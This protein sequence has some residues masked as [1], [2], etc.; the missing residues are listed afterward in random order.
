[1]NFVDEVKITVTAGNGGRGSISFRREK[2][3]P[4]GGPDGGDGG[5]GGSVYLVT[6][7][8]INTLSK[9]RFQRSFKAANGQAG[10]ARQCS[11]RRA[12]D[13][14]IPVPIGT[15]VYDTQTEELIGDL[16]EIGQQVLVAQGGTR[17]LGNVHFKSSTNRTPRRS[18]PGQGGEKRGL[19]LELK[20]LADV[21]LLGCPNAGKSTFVAAVS[22]ARPKIA[23]YPFTTLHPHLGV[24]TLDHDAQFVVADIPGLI[25]GA[26]QGSGLGIQFLKHLSRTQLLLH[27]VDLDPIDAHDPGVDIRTI[28]R[29]LAA[30]DTELFEKPRWLVFNKIDRVYKAD[31]RIAKIVSSIGWTQPVY[32]ISALQPS[33]CEALCRAI[34]ATMYATDGEETRA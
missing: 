8:G 16:T 33:S 15:Q 25:E 31:E 3:I 5:Q 9:F 4:R 23:D 34:L 20:V 7:P 27:L 21:G 13:L 24:V 32:A 12:D 6:D 22:N 14:H 11:G 19:N 17:G 2:Y 10:M 26:A 30:F 28:E 18:T 1:M 29:E